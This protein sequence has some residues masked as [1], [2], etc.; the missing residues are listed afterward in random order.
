MTKYNFKKKTT[1]ITK[2][3][4]GGSHGWPSHDRGY[5]TNP[6]GFGPG[7]PRVGPGPPMFGP[8]PPMFGPGPPMFG[9]G[10]P[11]FGPG[12]PMFGASGPGF[13][14]GFGPGVGASESQGWPM[15]RPGVGSG[16]GPGVGSGG[17]AWFSGV[18]QSGLNGN[19]LNSFRDTMEYYGLSGHGQQSGNDPPRLGDPSF[20]L[21]NFNFMAEGA[22]VSNL[23]KD[24]LNLNAPFKNIGEALNT[25]A[26]VHTTQIGLAPHF[27]AESPNVTL[28]GEPV[29]RI[30]STQNHKVDMFIKGIP[31][32]NEELIIVS[33]NIRAQ[34]MVDRTYTIR[35]GETFSDSAPMIKLFVQHIIDRNTYPDVIC[36]Q[37][38]KT[39][40]GNTDYNK[41]KLMLKS[42]NTD[43]DYGV[44]YVD[45]YANPGFT[46]APLKMTTPHT[47]KHDPDV[48]LEWT[49]V[50]NFIPGTPRLNQHHG[51]IVGFFVSLYCKESKTIGR[52]YGTHIANMSCFA[53][54]HK[55]HPNIESTTMSEILMFRN[56]AK[57]RFHNIYSYGSISIKH[58]KKILTTPPIITTV[59]GSNTRRLVLNTHD[60][61][62]T[63]SRDL[64]VLV[65]IVNGRK[66]V[67]GTSHSPFKPDFYLYTHS[68]V[69]MDTTQGFNPQNKP[70]VPDTVRIL[71]TGQHTHYGLSDTELDY[72]YLANIGRADIIKYNGCRRGTEEAIDHESLSLSVQPRQ[73]GLGTGIRPKRQLF[74]MNQIILTLDKMDR[75]DKRNYTSA[76]ISKV[77][78]SDDVGINR[79]YFNNAGLLIDSLEANL[80]CILTADWNVNLKK[81]NLY[82]TVKES[83]RLKLLKMSK[84]E[85]AEQKE[86]LEQAKKDEKEKKT[87]D[88]D[89]YKNLAEEKMRNAVYAVKLMKCSMLGNLNLNEYYILQTTS[90]SYIRRRNT[91]KAPRVKKTANTLKG[92]ARRIFLEKQD[93]ANKTL[94][95][96]LNTQTFNEE[97]KHNKIYR[98]DLRRMI[99]M[100][101]HPLLNELK[102]LLTA[103]EI[104]KFIEKS[105]TRNGSTMGSIHRK[106]ND[107]L[108]R[109]KGNS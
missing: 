89:Y 57:L 36:I 3:I 98:E 87:E 19:G 70:D 82:E 85:I 45:V 88:P 84:D 31:Q 62:N 108:A 66:V 53:L 73:M 90:H 12:P 81:P 47:F 65:L 80:P 11:M 94:R 10:P 106:V 75:K 44:D 40:F 2:K 27:R 5:D 51:G 96:K 43:M 20:G 107:M 86:L 60:N 71:N 103:K 67:I 34:S 58:N 77:R 92:V 95:N 9:P 76:F 7:P 74:D 8:G 78:S 52:D 48:Q 38:D 29:G 105:I 46:F 15:F 59:I 64:L 55:A 63:I 28:H 56:Q 61:S 97:H 35:T 49:L 83:A 33:A 99:I 30:E 41:G 6:G 69:R 16:V 18:A 21:R 25:G 1:K 23:R 17:P 93:K 24:I 100:S 14:P 102:S 32:V 26:N 101:E 13:G 37:E 54:Q 39:V 79:G 68:T 109:L 4:R 72:A 104:E 50:H 42:N 22:N 91:L